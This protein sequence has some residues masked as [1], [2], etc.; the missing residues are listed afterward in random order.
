MHLS[1]EL[2]D[3][4]VW[5][6]TLDKRGEEWNNYEKNTHTHSVTVLGCQPHSHVMLLLR[7]LERTRGAR[8]RLLFLEFGA[9]ASDVVPEVGGTQ[10]YDLLSVRAMVPSL[11]DTLKFASQKDRELLGH[12]DRTRLA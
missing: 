8:A 10:T 3:S 4:N 5:H 6:R 2:L 1:P 7:A 9:V 12:G 11:R